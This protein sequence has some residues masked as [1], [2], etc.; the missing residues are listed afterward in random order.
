MNIS[1]F[2]L[3]LFKVPAEVAEY[4]RENF[5][6]LTYETDTP[7]F[8]DGHTPHI[9]IF[10]DEGEVEIIRKKKIQKK[11]IKSTLLGCQNVLNK[12]PIDCEVR[13]KSRSVV[14]PIERSMLLKIAEENNT[15]AVY[16]KER[17]DY[18]S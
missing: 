2:D 14:Y 13:V 18:A 16:L 5:E 11:I 10:L 15:L 7:V 9:A 12:E 17:F 8:Y 4:I 1:I 6:P 3:S